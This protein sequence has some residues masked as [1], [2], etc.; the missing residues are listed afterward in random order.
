M[1]LLIKRFETFVSEYGSDPSAEFYITK[2]VNDAIAEGDAA[3]RVL[4]TNEQWVGV[5]YREDKAL[6]SAHIEGLR[7]RGLYPE[8]LW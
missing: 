6:A 5:T 8:E 4:T 2:P 1:T 7:A 3:V